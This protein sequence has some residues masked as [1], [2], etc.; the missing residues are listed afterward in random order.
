MA[1]LPSH[2]SAIPVMLVLWPYPA[3]AGENAQQDHLRWRSQGPCHLAW[4]WRPFPE[5]L[6]PRRIA[7]QPSPSLPD[8]VPASRI[9]AF[10]DHA[11]ASACTPRRPLSPS[12]SPASQ[13][14]P[15][16]SQSPSPAGSLSQATRVWPP[17]RA[18]T[19]MSVF[20]PRHLIQVWG[21]PWLSSQPHASLSSPIAC[22]SK[23]G[24][25]KCNFSVWK[26]THDT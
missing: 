4:L 18:G 15:C 2:V 13:P 1:F 7:A 11:G 10:P 22:L 8:S 9:P 5:H 16:S 12:P 25:F 17:G 3:P 14:E 21:H 20:W 26:N 23:T 19:C 6:G 24:H